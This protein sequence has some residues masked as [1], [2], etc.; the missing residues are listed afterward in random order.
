MFWE[1]VCLRRR[2]HARP[3]NAKTLVLYSGESPHYPASFYT[4][5]ICMARVTCPCLPR[6][7]KSSAR[8]TARPPCP[9]ANYTDLLNRQGYSAAISATVAPGGHQKLAHRWDFV[10]AALTHGGR[11]GMHAP[12][13]QIRSAD[14]VARRDRHRIEIG[15]RH[16]VMLEAL[17]QHQ[18]WS[19]TMSA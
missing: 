9:A 17:A 2:S 7:P 18:F 12:P 6:P 15:Q 19:S 1:I 16:A 5:C 10:T 3:P 4:A 13:R 14:R 11:S 8:A